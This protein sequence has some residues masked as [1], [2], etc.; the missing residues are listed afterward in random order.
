MNPSEIVELVKKHYEDPINWVPGGGIHCKTS[1]C[2]DRELSDQGALFK[3]KMVLNIGCFCPDDEL[4]FS[5][6]ASR[7]DAIDFC[8]SVIDRCKQLG[9]TTAN[10]YEMDARSMSFSPDSY[11]IVLDFSSGD[12]MPEE[13]Y[14]E[15]LKEV[16]RV[17]KPGGVFIVTF[18]NF[19]YFQVAETFSGGYARVYSAAELIA[20][21]QPLGFHLKTSHSLRCDRA[22]L[23]WIKE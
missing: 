11:D 9:L 23:L 2:V 8:K 22:G 13:H 21:I 14:D 12:Q 4:A 3:D 1:A 15:V 19:E 6:L 5:H 20:K 18:A 7:W 16:H 10:F 17:L